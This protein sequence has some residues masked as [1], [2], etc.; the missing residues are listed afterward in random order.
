MSIDLGDFPIGTPPTNSQAAQIRDALGLENVHNWDSTY[1]NVQSN[2]SY[3][4]G[5]STDTFVT[6]NSGNW[7]NTFTTVQS[8]SAAWSQNSIILNVVQLSSNYIIQSSDFG[9]LLLYSN[10]QPITAFV[11]SN[12][13]LNGFNAS[14][15][16]LS[17]GNITVKL[18]SN[19]TSSNLISYG[20]LFSTGGEG[21]TASIMRVLDNK[22]LLTG[23]LQ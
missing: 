4:I 20:S 14:F 1:T 6:A 16:Q 13:N 9:K 23:L 22:F 7:N 8:N 21:S 11:T 15:A 17:S 5:G 10:V 18:S 3:W 19:Y 12:I 2:S